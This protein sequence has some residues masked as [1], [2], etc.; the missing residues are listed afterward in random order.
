MAPCDFSRTQFRHLNQD[1][2]RRDFLKVISAG[3]LAS[4]LLPSPKSTLSFPEDQY[5]RVAIDSINVY[6]SP[7][8]KAK[9]INTHKK[10]TVF[11]ISGI[12]VGEGVPTNQIWYKVGEE[13]YAYSGDIQPVKI[14]LNP[15]ANKIPPLGALCEVTI[16]FTDAHWQPDLTSGI[17]Y[18][19]YFETTHWVTG[20][21]IDNNKLPWYRLS[22]I[23]FNSTYYVK[24]DHL[25]ILPPEELTPINPD[26]P[27]SAKRLEVRIKDQIIVAYENE[28]PVFMARASTGS[29]EAGTTYITPFGK[30]KIFFKRSTRHMESDNLASYGYDLPGVPWVCYFTTDGVAIHGTYWHNNFGFPRST[31]CVNLPSSAAK[32]IYRWTIPIVPGDKQSGYNR[33]GTEIRIIT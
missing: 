28:A 31:G 14:Q 33:N 11:L 12:I 13:G 3:F 2:S 15:V 9:I 7:S 30:Y 24:S 17:A 25:R 21:S 8:F 26:I 19:L 16:P 20:I 5:G 27:I 10:D 1:F 29:N 32:W 6:D 4:I 22:D 23:K 18:R